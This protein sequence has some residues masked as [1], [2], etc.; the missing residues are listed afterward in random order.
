MWDN[1]NH[2]TD[3]RDCFSSC[4]FDKATNFIKDSDITGKVLLD[5]GYFSFSNFSFQHPNL[6]IDTTPRFLNSPRT[7]D[8]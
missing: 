6:G 5:L 1:R 4:S 2:S 8:Y 7:Y 3:S